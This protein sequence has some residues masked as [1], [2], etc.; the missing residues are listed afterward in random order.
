MRFESCWHSLHVSCLAGR[1]SCHICEVH[2][3]SVVDEPVL[4]A[5]ATL[6]GEMEDADDVLAESKNQMMKNV[7][8]TWH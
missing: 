4:V 6:L 3:K 2:L 7:L 5:S 1:E 8:I